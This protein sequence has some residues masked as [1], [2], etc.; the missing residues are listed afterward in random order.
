M[1]RVPYRATR[2]TA[3]LLCGLLLLSAAG[4]PAMGNEHKWQLDLYGSYSEGDY[5]QDADTEMLYLPAAL[6]R[7][8]PWGR[9]SLTVPWIYLKAPASRTVVDG[10]VEVTGETD[11]ERDSH[12]GLG[13][14]ILKCEYE[15][16]EGD[17]Y[18]PWIDVFGKVKLPTADEDD[19]LGTGEVDVGVGV[20]MVKVF[21]GAYLGFLDVSFTRIGDPSGTD[22]DDRWALSPGVGRYVTPDLMLA[23]FYE[24]RQAV[25]G[26]DDPMGLSFLAS[27][28]LRSDLRAYGMFDIG[29]SDGEADFGLTL[30]VSLRF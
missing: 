13:D 18:W 22:Y 9:L 20:E 14:L 28:K 29:M 17:D 12:S 8:F 24:W 4:S 21:P 25:T 10:G 3:G 26:G 1:M 6:K 2:P 19:G 7:L 23:A 27:Q 5:G 11:G 16:A 30:G 15:L